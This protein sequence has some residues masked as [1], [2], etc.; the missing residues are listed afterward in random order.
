MKRLAAILTLATIVA[1]AF[2]AAGPARATETLPGLRS[3]SG[4]IKCLYLP[5]AGSPSRLLCTI[6]HASFAAKL[7][8]RCMGATGA[9]VDW[10]GFELTSA[11]RGNISCSGG[12]LYNPTTQHPSY[13]LLAYGKNWR[14]NAFTCQSRR[15][16]LTCRS[17]TGHGLFLS[18]SSWRVW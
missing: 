16:G 2:A 6:A 8:S 17:R 1:A 7:Q 4:N 18:L 3:P 10:H 15:T 9:G 11:R 12:I 14:H 13:T 5:G